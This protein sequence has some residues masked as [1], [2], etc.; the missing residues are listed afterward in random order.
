MA[1]P[2]TQ[3]SGFVAGPKISSTKSASFCSLLQVPELRRVQGG[4]QAV[5][6]RGGGHRPAPRGNP[7][8]GRDGGGKAWSSPRDFGSHPVLL[9]QLGENEEKRAALLCYACC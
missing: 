5:V 9:L 1:R 2:F 8:M 6:G 7:R 3:T 4:L